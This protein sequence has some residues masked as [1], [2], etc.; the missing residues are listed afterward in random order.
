MPSVIG[1]S[2]LDVRFALK[3]GHF[4]DRIKCPLCAK[5]GHFMD[6]PFPAFLLYSGV[7]LRG[8]QAEPSCR[9]VTVSSPLN[10]AVSKLRLSKSG[11]RQVLRCVRNTFAAGMPCM[12]RTQSPER[13][14]LQRVWRRA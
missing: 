14:I 1:T 8:P 6:P 13:K 4:V 3:S 7:L 2:P 10:Y 9:V 11:R 5:N 12:R